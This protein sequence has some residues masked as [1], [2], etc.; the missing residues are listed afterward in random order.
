MSALKTVRIIP[1][2]KI[3]CPGYDF[4]EINETDF[5]PDEHELYEPASGDARTKAE[6][7]AELTALGIP[8]N[9]RMGKGD[10]L[11]LFPAV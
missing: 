5:N 7:I 10:L 4:V 9:A 1:T 11:A 8:V 3:Q 6:L 2:D